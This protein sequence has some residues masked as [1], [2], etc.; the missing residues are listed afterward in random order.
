MFHY[1]LARNQD[2]RAAGQGLLVEL[3]AWADRCVRRHAH[4]PATDSPDQAVYATGWLPLLYFHPDH[5]AGRYLRTLRDQVSGRFTE[6]GA[7]TH[8][9]WRLAD[10]AIGMRH[11]EMFLCPLARLDPEMVTVGEILDVAE[12]VGNWNPD[13]PPWFDEEKQCFR[14]ATFG[15]EAVDEENSGG[16]DIPDHFH[17][18]NLVLSALR[19]N[20]SRRYG[21]WAAKYAG[22]WAQAVLAADELPVGLG[23]EGPVYEPSISG[24]EHE[25]FYRAEALLAV[26]AV[27]AFLKL[28]KITG[29]NEFRAA[30]EKLLD[31]L[32]GELADPD[33]NSLIAALRFY[34]RM[35][36]SDRYDGRVAEELENLMPFR[37]DVIDLDTAP[38]HDPSML[39]LGKADDLPHWREDGQN[40]QHNPLLLGLAA[41]ILEEPTLA[42]RALDLGTAYLS[43]AQRAFP[44]GRDEGDSARTVA[45]IA[46]GNLRDNGAGVITEVL[47]PLMAR[48]K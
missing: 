5:P 19:L 6:S 31:A 14:S 11:F 17:C 36:K 43:L 40:R 16:F 21:D 35:T 47:V 28:W 1:K 34:R 23:P 7:W 27:Q 42:A 24:D 45:A 33:A 15:T 4:E 10:V 37:I 29:I 25:N 12:H 3:R 26:D 41:E 44:D 20:R 22:R 32:I 38:F 46:R 39:G 8:G 30:A 13:A 2:P 48:F 18:V 9:Y